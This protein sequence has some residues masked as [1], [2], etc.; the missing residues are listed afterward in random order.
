MALT[1]VDPSV[2]DDQ[3]VGRRNMIYNG[4]MQV[5]QRN[6]TGNTQV[7]WTNANHYPADRWGLIGSSLANWAFTIGNRTDLT[8]PDGFGNAIKFDC[9]TADTS[10]TQGEYLVLQQRFEGSDLQHLCYGT[11]S[12][13]EITLSFYINSTSTGTYLAELEQGSY[14]NGVKFTIDQ[15][16]TWERKTITFTGNTAASLA[17]TNDFALTL[18]LWFAAG[19]TYQGG[20]FVS[21][22]WRNSY[23]ANTRAAGISN[24][25]S[26]TS[27]DLFITGVQLEVGDQATV[28]EHRSIGEELELC[29]RY[30][31]LNTPNVG[32]SNSTTSVRCSVTGTTEM[33]A[34][35]SISLKYGVN[36]IEQYAVATRNITNIINESGYGT[37]GG[38]SDVTVSTTT[39]G[40]PH[41]LYG[42]AIAM[43]ADFLT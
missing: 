36:K 14:I 35:P 7:G 40:V 31:Q 32:R 21:N 26:S 8:L 17:N 20:T 13:K 12:A 27:N 2:V 15:A 38:L 42:G 43:N 18:G 37:L 25:A 23:A 6:G 29:K 22:T 39:S 24:L 19:D 1:K 4:K 10:L 28:F 30:Y 5:S 16:N 11:S 3:V 41:A 33:R 34:A 9:T